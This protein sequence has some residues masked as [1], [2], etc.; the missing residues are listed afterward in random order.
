MSAELI[1]FSLLAVIAILSAV[2]MLTSKN[3]VHSALWLVLNL[4]T[5]GVFYIILRRSLY[6]HGANYRL[7]RGNYG[8][9]SCL[10][11]CFWALNA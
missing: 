1:I 11:L 10:S 2:F 9:F 5:I 3:A 7:R 8:A 4:S 6:R